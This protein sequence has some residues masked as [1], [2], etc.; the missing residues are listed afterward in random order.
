MQFDILSV[1]C[2]GFTWCV[3]LHTSFKAL[4]QMLVTDINA[5]T[6]LLLRCHHVCCRASHISEGQ[7][8]LYSDCLAGKKQCRHLG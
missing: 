8:S 7:K 6:C 4:N 5:S 1:Q 3:D 2:S